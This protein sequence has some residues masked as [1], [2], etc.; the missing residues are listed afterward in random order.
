[1][2][3][4]RIWAVDGLKGG[5]AMEARSEI[6]LKFSSLLPTAKPAL[7]KKIEIQLTEQNRN[8]ERKLSNG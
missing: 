6:N 5:F 8:V 4:A 7:N 1:V 2:S 3:T